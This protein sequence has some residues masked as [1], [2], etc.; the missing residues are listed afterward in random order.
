MPRGIN[1]QSS[2][3]EDSEGFQYKTLHFDDSGQDVESAHPF[4]IPLLPLSYRYS[5]S[6]SGAANQ[7]TANDILLITWQ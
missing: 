1:S 2:N 3:L 7:L 6:Q 5:E 4:L